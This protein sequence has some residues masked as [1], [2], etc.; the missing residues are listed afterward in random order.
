VIRSKIFVFLLT[1]ILSSACTGESNYEKF[2]AAQKIRQYVEPAFGNTLNS[3]QPTEKYGAEAKLLLS[4]IRDAYEKCN[5]K[6][7]LSI[8][9]RNFKQAIV[10]P[11]SRAI[12]IDRRDYFGSMGTEEIDASECNGIQR[13]LSIAATRV[14][15]T[16]SDGIDIGAI[17]TYESKFFSPRFIETFR[18]RREEQ[19]LVLLGKVSVP[20]YPRSVEYNQINLYVCD[21]GSYYEQPVDVTA[22]EDTDI[23]LSRICKSG[24]YET[25]PGIGRQAVLLVAREPL[26]SGTKVGIYHRY[27]DRNGKLFDTFE[28]TLTVQ[29]VNPWFFLVTTT[30]LNRGHVVYDVRID[31]TKILEQTYRVQ[32]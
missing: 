19:R 29:N 18:F 20:L 1:P 22:L 6:S 30:I 3:F 14:I 7:L 10:L 23:L 12:A 26:P 24:A 32:S 16:D 15:N 9:A 13:R 4:T 5:K 28:R 21:L 2:E 31:G 8:F 27:Y 11:S 17:T 25:L